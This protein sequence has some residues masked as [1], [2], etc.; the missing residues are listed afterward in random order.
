MQLK[1]YWKVEPS[2]FPEPF[3]TITYRKYNGTQKDRLDWLEICKN[4]LVGEDDDESKFNS[5]FYGKPDFTEDDLYFVFDGDKAVATIC[6][7]YDK[8]SGMGNVHMVS[9]HDSARGKGL[10]GY[11][12]NI[13]KAHLSLDPCKLAYLTTDEWRVPAIKSYLKSGFLPVDC[14]DDMEERWT[15]WLTEQGYKNIPFL[16]EQGNVKKLLCSE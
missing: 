13:V 15:K 5:S 2:E 8:E 9:V 10:G 12:N 7:I 1:M 14:A 11:I 4:G 16:D 6:G 3:G